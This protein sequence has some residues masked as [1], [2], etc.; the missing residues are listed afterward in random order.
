MS[1]TLLVYNSHG[2][3]NVK[4]LLFIS[5]IPRLCLLQQVLP[6]TRQ[7]NSDYFWYGNHTLEKKNKVT[8]AEIFRRVKIFI[9]STQ[10]ENI[11]YS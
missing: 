10:F 2:G 4:K 1:S 9:P 5:I 8:V 6:P 11:N 7:A 3:R